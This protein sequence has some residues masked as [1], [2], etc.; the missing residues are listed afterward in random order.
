MIYTR[1][2]SE[3]LN[4]HEQMGKKGKSRN[5]QKHVYQDSLELRSMVQ[6]VMSRHDQMV[7][8]RKRAEDAES[9][10]E[11]L[12]KQIRHMEEEKDVMGAELI[13]AKAF[14]SLNEER[15]TMVEEVEYAN[16]ELEKRIRRMENSNEFMDAELD[17]ANALIKV[18]EERVMMI[19]SEGVI[20]VKDV[21]TLQQRAQL[22]H[23]LVEHGVPFGD[24]WGG[25]L[26]NTDPALTFEYERVLEYLPVS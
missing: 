11:E 25:H 21:L 7:A 15:A 12:H 19:L 2:K 17:V 26:G 5:N 10:N 22:L 24:E 13:V 4:Q 3:K 9:A 16:E 6:A 20:D 14:G 18:N 8:W 1:L 23:K